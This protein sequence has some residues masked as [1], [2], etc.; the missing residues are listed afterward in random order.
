[1]STTR[2]MLEFATP[3]AQE[4]IVSS[5]SL[6]RPRGDFL[7]HL[8]MWNAH[9]I[10][11]MRSLAR[12]D[13]GIVSEY[14]S[15]I[16]GEMFSQPTKIPSTYLDIRDT[17]NLICDHVNSNR[18]KVKAATHTLEVYR[19][20]DV[21]LFCLL[22]YDV[23]AACNN[24]R[25]TGAELTEI[26]CGMLKFSDD[27]AGAFMYSGL[28]FNEFARKVGRSG[29]AP[30]W[31]QT[32]PI[33]VFEGV[34]VAFRAN[35]EAKGPILTASADYRMFPS[36]TRIVKNTLVSCTSHPRAIS[37][38]YDPYAN[39]TLPKSFRRLS[40][41]N[42]SKNYGKNLEVYLG[43]SLL[44]IK[45]GDVDLQNISLNCDMTRLSHVSARI[46]RLTKNVTFTTKE[47]LVQMP[48]ETMPEDAYYAFLRDTLDI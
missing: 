5:V 31:A 10:E 37:F 47:G 18:M 33:C 32:E 46:D 4:R 35:P 21:L 19:N 16:A 20:P 36:A 29:D 42:P 6:I 43:P 12:F 34:T 11:Q 41:F 15:W 23:L 14:L 38:T 17:L 39:F 44:C 22:K 9:K 3:F 40:T 8:S 45:A 26:F 28:Y 2:E 1:M 27:R 48:Y 13:E 7:R 25:A 24:S 30:L